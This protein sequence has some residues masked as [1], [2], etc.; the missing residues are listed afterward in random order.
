MASATAYYQTLT[1]LTDRLNDISTIDPDANSASF[2]PA[3]MAGPTPQVQAHAG[4]LVRG[5]KLSIESATVPAWVDGS[6]QSI[7]K[8]MVLPTNWDLHGAPPVQFSAVQTA[9]DT[10]SLFMNPATR[11]PQWTPTLSGGIQLDWHQNALDLEIT[12][13]PGCEGYVL[14]SDHRNPD[15]EWEGVVTEHLANMRHI[16]QSRLDVHTP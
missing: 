2:F 13:E 1:G 10:L 9:M 16:V 15:D 5:F 8:L 14:F 11:S 6:V 3:E 7:G 12:F 4:R